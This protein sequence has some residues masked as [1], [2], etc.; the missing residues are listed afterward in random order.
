M[1]FNARDLNLLCASA[2]CFG[3]PPHLVGNVSTDRAIVSPYKPH[4]PLFFGNL[5]MPTCPAKI[6]GS[7]LGCCSSNQ[8][9]LP[10]HAVL[11]H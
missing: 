7:Q 9:R 4:C 5:E 10:Q 1:P 11:L 8:V 6:S 2:S 3:F